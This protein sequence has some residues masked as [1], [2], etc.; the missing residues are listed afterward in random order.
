[1]R[2][3]EREKMQVTELAWLNSTPYPCILLMVAQGPIRRQ[4]KKNLTI[5]LV[6]CR[7]VAELDNNLS[8]CVRP[9]EERY[10]V[11]QRTG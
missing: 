10:R 3:K 8:S 2:K 5:G 1:M 6:Y 11:T 4:R 7:E 9:F